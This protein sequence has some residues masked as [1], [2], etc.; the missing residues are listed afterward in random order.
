MQKKLITYHITCCVFRSCLFQVF[1]VFLP[2]IKK[3]R[4]LEDTSDL[5]NTKTQAGG[6]R[7]GSKVIRVKYLRSHG[8]GGERGAAVVLCLYQCGYH[9]LP[10]S[11]LASEM[12]GPIKPKHSTTNVFMVLSL[13]VQCCKTTVDNSAILL[14]VSKH[15]STKHVYGNLMWSINP[16]CFNKVILL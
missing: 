6:G 4:V 3:F 14:L 7:G 15:E 10:F 9:I 1:L 11:N 13:L 2:L 12:Q 5:P 8:Q 16:F